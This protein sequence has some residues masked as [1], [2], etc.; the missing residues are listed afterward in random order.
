MQNICRFCGKSIDSTLS[1]CSYCNG[2][3]TDVIRAAKDQPLTIRALQEWYADKGLPPYE[4]TR[5][6]I[7]MDYRQPRAYGIYQEQESRH[8]I[9]YKNLSSGERK[10]FYD[11]TDEAY[12]VNAIY[13]RIVTEIME[14]KM[15]RLKKAQGGNH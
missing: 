10:V 7:G 2:I 6:F 15:L 14:Q 12:A 1:N 9:V 8:F 4:T 13:Q 3:N 11:G 5:F